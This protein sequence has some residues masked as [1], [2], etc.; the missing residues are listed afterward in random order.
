LPPNAPTL[1]GMPVQMNAFVDGDHAGNQVTC[2]SHTGI[3]V[4]LCSAQIIW[5][6][7][8]QV[9]WNHPPLV[10]SLSLWEWQLIW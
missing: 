5:Y 9:Q 1:R 4:Y 3:L 7:K 8:A 6:S 2:R 10:Q